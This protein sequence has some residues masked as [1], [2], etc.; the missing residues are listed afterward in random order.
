MPE[1]NTLHLGCYINWL[2][3][4]GMREF[5]AGPLP[6]IQGAGYD[7]V[8]FVQPLNDGLVQKARALGLGVCGSGRVNEPVELRI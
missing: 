3:L 1:A 5:P 6:A 4:D 7:G 2:A 8:Q